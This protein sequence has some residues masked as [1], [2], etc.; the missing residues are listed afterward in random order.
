MANKVGNA[1]CNLWCRVC[2]WLAYGGTPMTHE[3]LE[4]RIKADM[5]DRD[6]DRFLPPSLRRYPATPVAPPSD[7]GGIDG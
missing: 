5:T 2:D 1:I 3:E 7:R 4:A 6:V